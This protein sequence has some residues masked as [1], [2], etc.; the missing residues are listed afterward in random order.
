[1]DWWGRYNRDQDKH[2]M[3]GLRSIRMAGKSCGRFAVVAWRKYVSQRD[4]PQSHATSPTNH[5][6]VNTS[7]GI[8]WR[9]NSG[10]RYN[11][12]T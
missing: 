10:K 4:L 6:V 5:L 9:Y 8:V 12:H 2:G 1:M 3:V 11:P 7:K